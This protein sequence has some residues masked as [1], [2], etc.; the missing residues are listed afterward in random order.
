VATDDLT[1]FSQSFIAADSD[2]LTRSKWL[3]KIEACS[4][5]T[6]NNDMLL[7]IPHEQSS[8]WT[9]TKLFHGKSTAARKN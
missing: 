8:Q 7:K 9:D 5:T 2:E 3:F 4:S 1:D 6:A